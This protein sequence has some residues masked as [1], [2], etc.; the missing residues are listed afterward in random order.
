MLKDRVHISHGIT[1]LGADIPSVSFPIV[2]SCNPDA[3]CFKKCYAR[4]GRFSFPHNKDLLERNLTI[5]KE[6]P[7]RF[8]LELKIAAFH[9]RF[10][11][12]FSSG[13]IPDESFFEMMVR[14]ARELPDTQ[15]LAFTKK[16]YIVNQYIDQHGDLPENLHMVFSAWGNWMQ[17]NPYQF[18]VAYIRFK[19]ELS[20]PVPDSAH[21][22]RKYCGDCVMTGHSCWNLEKGESVCFTEH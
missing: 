16:G 8:E 5:W 19:H 18:P 17:E 21:Q 12:Y 7:D 15:F 11:R 10:F 20:G 14:V 13:D 1:K 6:S 22:C 4:R 2:K 3:P 9:S